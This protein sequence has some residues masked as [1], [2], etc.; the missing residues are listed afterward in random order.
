MTTQIIVNANCGSEK[1]VKIKVTDKE[2]SNEITLKNGESIEA[3]NAQ[4]QTA[5]QYAL[6]ANKIPDEMIQFALIPKVTFLRDCGEMFSTYE[7]SGNH[8][9]PL[10]KSLGLESS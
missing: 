1:E 2:G 8:I 5:L 4:G 9:Q 10:I 7:P 3:L 6:S